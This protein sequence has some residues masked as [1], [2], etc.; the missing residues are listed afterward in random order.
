[1]IIATEQAKKRSKHMAWMDKLGCYVTPK[2][3]LNGIF[4]DSNVYY[5]GHCR[6]M[7]NQILNCKM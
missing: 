4:R 3:K 7:K 1:M 5:Y 2:H 6:I